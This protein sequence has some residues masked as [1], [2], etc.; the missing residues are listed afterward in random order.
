M[1]G[2]PGYGAR[3]AGA[4]G[5]GT[6]AIDSPPAARLRV[7]LDRSLI[8]AATAAWSVVTM[9]ALA[10]LAPIPY[11]PVVV[12]GYPLLLV[13][14]LVFTERAAERDLRAAAAWAAVLAA[15]YFLVPRVAADPQLALSGVAVVVAGAVCWRFPSAAVIALFATAAVQASVLAF[16]DFDLVRI[17]DLILAGLWLGFVVRLAIGGREREAIVWPAA[18]ACLGYL[19]M[20]AT[21]A[22]TAGPGLGM[23]AFRVAAWF[24][25]AFLLIAYAG[26]SDATR[27]R[28][29][30]GVV[31]VTAAVAAYAVLRWLIGPAAEEEAQALSAANGLNVINGHLRVVGSF[32]TGHQ[33]AFWAGLM[34]PFCL[35][36]A[37]VWGGRWRLV[38][39]LAVVL[40]AFASFASEARGPL[41]GMVVGVAA[42]LVVHQLSI[43]PRRARTAISV[44]AV[45]AIALVGGVAYAVTIDDPNG[46]ARY[47]R[48]V[49]PM[50]DPAYAVRVA[51]WE[52]AFDE[53]EGH[54]FGLGLGTAGQVND[55]SGRFRTVASLNLDNSYIKVAYEQGWIVLAYFV[56][57]LLALLLTMAA[58]AIRARSGELAGPAIGAVGA[59]ASM[60]VSFYT[61]LYIEGLIA[62]SGWI[63]VGLGIS[64]LVTR[65]T[66]LRRA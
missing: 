17:A 46:R 3:R 35:A 19:A 16:F 30:R 53:L 50:S 49:D 10:G 44:I 21:L 57:A 7:V 32:L 20:T 40:C 56:V 63:V 31:A 39:G 36:I 64:G 52:D 13:C 59:L 58:A 66:P 51:K 37:L 47:E 1:S 18:L 45:S 6:V 2:T 14:A 60:L 28:I 34:A 12:A 38:A 41:A 5:L 26:F 25:L 55:L 42:V 11:A 43:G 27:L 33:L 62:L 23:P 15:A 22:L 9:V 54:P 29:V 61:G 24:M 4:S 48:I 65:T 8:V